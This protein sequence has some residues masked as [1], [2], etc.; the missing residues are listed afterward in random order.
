[1][2]L[3]IMSYKIIPTCQLSTLIVAI[4]ISGHGVHFFLWRYRSI[5]GRRARMSVQQESKGMNTF[6]WIFNTQLEEINIS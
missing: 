6:L 3:I 4:R 5:A 1:M 2:T